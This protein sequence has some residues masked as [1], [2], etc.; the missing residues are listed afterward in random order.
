MQSRGELKYEALLVRLEKR[1]ARRFLYLVSYTLAKGTGDVTFTGPSRGVTVAEHPEWDWGPAANDRRHAL[2]A[3]GAVQM[4][5]DVMLGAVWTLRST[6]PFSAVAGRDLNGDGSITD[7]VPGTTRAQ[8]NRNLDLSLVNAWRASLGLAPIAASQID[9]NRYNSLD[10]RANKAFSLGAS[11]KIE[12]IGQVFNVMGTENLQASGGAGGW[13]TN[14]TS[15]SFG[16]ILTAQNGRQAEVAVRV[17][18]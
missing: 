10:V 6:M 15:D 8:G 1:L 13:T 3:S 9:N 2:V 17:V 16:R 5:G 7:Y 18:F 14:A 12:V 4:P 11:R